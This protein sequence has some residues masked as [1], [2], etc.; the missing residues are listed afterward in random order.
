MAQM[1]KKK[2]ACSAGDLGWENTLEKGTGTHSSIL[3]VYCSMEEPGGLQTTGH[4][5]FEL[6][7]EQT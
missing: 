3:A 1:V 7:L 6:H 2:S 5:V 4:G